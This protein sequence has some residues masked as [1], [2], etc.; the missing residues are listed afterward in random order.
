MLFLCFTKNHVP[1]AYAAQ[2]INHCDTWCSWTCHR[3]TRL[4]RD[5][6]ISHVPHMTSLLFSHWCTGT[7]LM[8]HSLICA[9]SITALTETAGLFFACALGTHTVCIRWHF[10]CQNRLDDLSSVDKTFWDGQSCAS[11]HTIDSFI[12][13]VHQKKKKENTFLVSFTHPYIIPNVFQGGQ[14]LSSFKKHNKSLIKV[15]HK[16]VVGCANDG[17][18]KGQ[19]LWNLWKNCL[20]GLYLFYSLFK[21]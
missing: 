12:S 14:V 5:S 7:W 16:F 8:S 13:I 10:I 18:N 6:L 9:V 15:V 17:K 3:M 19:N 20:N 4:F 11:A 1:V 21:F 2:N